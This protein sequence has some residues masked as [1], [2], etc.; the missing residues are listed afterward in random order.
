MTPET[1]YARSGD[2]SIAYQ[3]IGNGPLDLVYVMGWV[4]NIEYYWQ[5]PAMKRFLKRLSSF[6]RL[7]VFDKRGTG[8]SDK[9]T[10]LPTLEQRMD[11]V[12]AVMD[13]VGSQKAALLGVSEGG[14]M[15]CLFAA[16]YP[17]RTTA[18]I[19]YGSYARRAWAPDYP[20]APTPEE[21]EVFYD[22]IKNGWGG[23]VDLDT[24]APSMMRNEPFKKWWAAY[25]R[26]SASPADALSLAKM[27]TD[28]DTR[29]ILS[30]IHV[31]TLVIHRTGDMDIS[32]EGSKYMAKQIPNAKFVELPGNDHLLWVGDTANILN[33]IEIFL[34]GELHAREPDRILTTCLFT[35]IVNSTAALQSMGDERWRVLLQG[36]NE[37]VRNQL[38]HFKGR[39]IK[40]TG[41]GFLATF[42]GPARA[43]RCACAIRD[44]VQKLGIEIRAGLHT[45][46]CDVIDNDI[47]GLSVHTTERIM[48]Q[49]MPGEV[50]SSNTVKDLVAG[51]G[52]QFEK[53]GL[54][55]LKGIS[56]E[57]EIYAV[58]A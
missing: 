25:L 30:A 29:N 26:H 34:T 35:D 41:D 37:I 27:N 40:T 1:K 14:P 28:I 5:D 22:A 20:W 38:T 50:L 31:P 58:G 42:D 13:A 54:F 48:S 12:R 2:V 18:L 17:E 39:E 47:S 10:S 6:A 44:E 49:A 56:G 33:E 21:R 23:V 15:C 53:K 43:V 16:T 36:H 8:L 32:V 46:E 3:V 19:M 7:I 51:S 52:L 9:V 57:W 4:S 45:G 11:D 55:S 24:L